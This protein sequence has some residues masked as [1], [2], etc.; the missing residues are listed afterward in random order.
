MKKPT[1]QKVRDLTSE[2]CIICN[3][4]M[5]RERRIPTN[6]GVVIVSVCLKHN[7]IPADEILG[8]IFN[9]V[10]KIPCEKE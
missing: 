8:V 1:A 4:W 9:N 6:K 3:E 10:K 5:Y 7:G 2:R